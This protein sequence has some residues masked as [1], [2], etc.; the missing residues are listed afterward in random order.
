[1][2][3]IATIENFATAAQAGFILSLQGAAKDDNYAEAALAICESMTKKE[4]SAL[5]TEL[6]A[7]KPVLAP[8]APVVSKGE[9]HC[10]NGNFYLV[11]K[12]QGSGKL[13]AK[14]RNEGGGFT[15]AGGVVFKLSNETKVNAS[16]IDAIKAFAHLHTRCIFC[17]LPL[18]QP[19]SLVAGYGKKCS[20]N[21]GL[22]W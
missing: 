14:Q 7:A 19:E 2:T 20:E 11:A 1:M 16:H 22:P 3:T 13:Y 15:Y 10:L 21:H 18:D 17:Y 4:A 8:K 5:I 9:W 6:K 12:A